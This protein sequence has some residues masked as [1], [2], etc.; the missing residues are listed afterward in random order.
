[1]LSQKLR[2]VQT[3]MQKQH[4]DT[5]IIGN[6]G[7]QVA[8]DL[9]YY[10]LLKKLEYGILVIPKKGAPTLYGISFEAAQLQ[11]AYPSLRVAPLSPLDHILNHHIQKNKIIGIRSSSLPLNVFEA[12]RK[13][14]NTWKHFDHRGLVSVKLPGEITRMKKAARLTD[15]I[16]SRLIRSWKKFRTEQDTARFILAQC[17]QEHIEPSF[18]PIIAS[19]VR[20]ADP[21]HESVDLPLI[22]GFC[23]IDMGV[24][25]QGYCSDMT[26]TI[27]LGTPNK[28]EIALYELIKKIQTATI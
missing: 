4:I 11:R 27:F 24:R 23:V 5:L 13:K 20:A 26:R 18:S 12:I 25:Y 7:H 28:K 8:D 2:K 6:F 14:K 17:V 21:H 1:M 10:L 9:L 22:R 3:A 19:G 16:F 15:I